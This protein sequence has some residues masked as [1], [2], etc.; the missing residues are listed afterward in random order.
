MQAF[1]KP[2]HQRT[3]TGRRY[4]SN[5]ADY[6]P[7]RLAEMLRMHVVAVHKDTKQP[8]PDCPACRDL[9]GAVMGAK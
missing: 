2:R 9:V 4:A 7:E 3:R 5:Q 8:Q 1:P 6:P